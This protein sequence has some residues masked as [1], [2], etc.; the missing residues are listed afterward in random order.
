MKEQRD[1]RNY[2]YCDAVAHKWPEGRVFK[3]LSSSKS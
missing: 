3:K 1:Q 2:L